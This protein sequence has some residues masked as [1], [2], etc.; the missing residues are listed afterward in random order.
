MPEEVVFWKWISVNTVGLVTEAAVYHWTMEGETP[1]TKVFDRHPTLT[2]C[3]IIN[4]R[5]EPDEKWLC[6]VGISAQV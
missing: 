4:Y 2:G 6:L 1:P 3:Q 5:I